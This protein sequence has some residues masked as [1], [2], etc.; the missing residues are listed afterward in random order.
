MYVDK[1]QCQF[2]APG[3]SC[4]VQIGD[5]IQHLDVLH[6]FLVFLDG[7]GVGL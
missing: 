2:L 5:I 6:N 1:S 7:Y 3:A 4:V